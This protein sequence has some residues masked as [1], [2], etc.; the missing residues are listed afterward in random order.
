MIPLYVSSLIF[1]TSFPFT[2]ILH[3]FI[4]PWRFGIVLLN[5]LCGYSNSSSRNKPF[6]IL[7][8]SELPHFLCLIP[9]YSTWVNSASILFVYFLLC[10]LILQWPGQYIGTMLSNKYF[11]VWMNV[12]MDMYMIKFWSYHLPVVLKKLRIKPRQLM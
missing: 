4:C 2:R 6:S 9:L 5:Y 7:S 3:A 1:F 11:W 8:G 12:W 10:E